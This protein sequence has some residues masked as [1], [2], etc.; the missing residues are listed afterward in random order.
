LS[1]TSNGSTLHYWH[2]LDLLAQSDGTQTEYLAYDGLGSVRQVTDS[3]GIVEMAQTFDPYRNLYSRSGLNPTKYAFSGEAQDDN[4]LLFLRA[5]YYSASS[6]RFLNTDPS[7]QEQN[8]YQYGMSNP[9]MHTDPSGLLSTVFLTT[10]YALTSSFGISPSIAEMLAGVLGDCDTVGGGTTSQVT[11][12]GLSS[13]AGLS[14][15]GDKA[16]FFD[17][18]VTVYFD[19]DLKVAEKT[20][21]MLNAFD[22]VIAISQKLIKELGWPPAKMGL[23]FR[24]F[25]NKAVEIHVVSSLPQGCQG[26]GGV[27]CNTGSLSSGAN[28]SV[29]KDAVLNGTSAYGLSV[30]PTQLLVHELGHTFT[31]PTPVINGVPSPEFNGNPA[32]Y[33]FVDYVG[34]EDT[35]RRIAQQ[36]FGLWAAKKDWDG[37]DVSASEITADAFLNWALGSNS[38]PQVDGFMARM[39]DYRFPTTHGR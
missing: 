28:I 31:G 6:G 29:L 16:V 25:F 35:A 26:E 4:G 8:P 19:T 34:G 1:E 10:T 9:V 27:A 13:V 15:A 17:F 39:I 30:T 22:A 12:V 7:R 20:Q 14:S 21:A 11:S 37:A 32:I 36:N 38:I 5:R 3:A 18:D 2:G 24:K 23:A 33:S